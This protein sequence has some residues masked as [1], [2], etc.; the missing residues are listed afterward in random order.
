MKIKMDFI[1]NSSSTSFILIYG[2]EFGLDE[3]LELVGM[4]KESDF[5][6]LFAR[7]Y[8][9]LWEKKEPIRETYDDNMIKERFSEEVLNRILEAEKEGKKVFV[10]T[11][12][13]ENDE[14]ESFFC[15]DSFII[16][17]DTFYLN[18]INCIW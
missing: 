14:I 11:L 1:T 16:E 5:G 9:E 10:G 7:L 18:A 12:S 3:F 17:N 4:K 2:T 6:F 13:S 8:Q 15:T